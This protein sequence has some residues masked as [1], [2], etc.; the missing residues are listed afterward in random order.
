[1]IPQP[2]AQE[3]LAG[4]DNDPGRIALETGWGTLLP[5]QEVP[6]AV[7]EWGLGAG[8]SSVIAA[9]LA[10]E[11]AIAVL[12]DAEAR[13]CARAFGLTVL[14]TLGVVLRAAKKGRISQAAPVIHKLR[15]AGLYLH[16]DVVRQALQ[17]TL[18]EPWP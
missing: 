1:M 7:K 14:G 8:E 3:I 2:V 10:S 4:P 16:E 9:T 12:D 17:R 5:P 6:D 18:A 13:I 15:Q 11:D